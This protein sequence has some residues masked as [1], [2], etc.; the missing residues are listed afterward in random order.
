MLVHRTAVPVLILAWAGYGH[1]ASLE[2]RLLTPLS[3]YWSKPGDKLSAVTVA[4]A[5]ARSGTAPPGCIVTGTVTASLRV[6]LGLVRETATLKLEFT[7]LRLPDGRSYP[8]ESRLTDVPNAR[9]RVDRRGAIRGI[10]A[11]ASLSHR[12]AFRVGALSLP[13]PFLVLPGFA[14]QAAFL[15][16]PNPEIDFPAG[17]ELRLA[18]AHPLQVDIPPS[19]LT[20]VANIVALR[21]AVGSMPYWV[22]DSAGPSDITNLLLVGSRQEMDRAFDSAGWTTSVPFSAASRWQAVR[23]IA[24]KHSYPEAPMRTLTLAGAPADASRQKT[25]NTFEKRHHLRIWHRPESW[26]GRDVWLIAASHDVGTTFSLRPFGFTHTIDPNVDT[27]RNKVVHDLEF[28]GC[29]DTVGWAQRASEL[30]VADGR[31]RSQ[32]TTDHRVAIVVLNSCTA[33]GQTEAIIT[34]DRGPG[35][36]VRQIRRVTL[37]GRNHLLRNNLPWR[38]Y[39]AG[40]LGARVFRSWKR[41][42][43]LS[44]QREAVHATR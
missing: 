27:E 37:V 29:V 2:V 14:V 16:F 39:E 13:Y 23:A 33:T 19:P 7:E 40:K 3:S 11:T 21:E 1:A 35:V 8:I 38:T 5:E 42:R 34:E 31:D 25:L 41:S 32:L 15:R 9:E 18:L 43:A 17:T 6:G 10:R 12:T 20:E 44:R 26:G 28:T 36:M 22:Y 4:P 24:E 30:R